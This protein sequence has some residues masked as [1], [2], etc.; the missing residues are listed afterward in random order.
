[1]IGPVL[2]TGGAGYIGSHTCKALAQS[3]FTPVCFDSLE[4]GHRDAVQWGP[5]EVGNL[6]DARAL[7]RVFATYS[8]LAVIH[9]AAFIEVGESVKEPA[10]FYRNN[11]YGTLCLLDAMRRAEVSRIVFSSTCAV[12]GSPDT[13]PIREDSPQ[14]PVSPYGRT[15]QMIEQILGDYGQSYGFRSAI[16]RYFNAC[17]A[18]PDGEVGERHSPETHLIPRALMAAAGGLPFLG[19]FGTDYPTPDGTC[20]RDYIHVSDL[21]RGHG[22]A[23]GHLLGGGESVALNLGTG[24]GTSV[25]EIIA[26]VETVT[27]R[28]VPVQV[29]PRREGD[30]PCLLADP[31]RAADVLGFR[32]LYNDIIPIVESAW[33]YHLRHPRILG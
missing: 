27:K 26:A 31:T 25:Q 15:K 4:R 11:V 12:Y 2:V 28:A 20:I 9:F 7:D 6:T 29:S 10:A 24:R 33:A 18:D 14:N 22:L 32:T 30:P 13:V 5:L 1:M 19:V 8:P 23:L 17:G 21:A 16:L 3:G